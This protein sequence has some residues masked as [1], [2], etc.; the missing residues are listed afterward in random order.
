MFRFSRL[1][2]APSQLETIVLGTPEI[3]AGQPSH[4]APPPVL[5]LFTAL[6]SLLLPSSC[7][8]LQHDF[9]NHTLPFESGIILQ[10]RAFSSCQQA[11]YQICVCVFQ[12]K[13]ASLSLSTI[14]ISPLS[15]FRVGSQRSWTRSSRNM[16]SRQ[17]QAERGLRLSSTPSLASCAH[18]CEQ[19]S[20]SPR[21]TPETMRG[22]DGSLAQQKKTQ[23]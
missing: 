12:H 1:L 5:R 18:Q 13:S 14:I 6:F 4:T 20:W 9:A 3:P 17:F 7:S 23:E 22:A 2:L 19:S 15:S 16:R 8:A 10:R 21:A 11:E